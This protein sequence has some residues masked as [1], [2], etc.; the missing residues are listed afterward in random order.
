MSVG[1]NR[2]NRKLEAALFHHR[3]EHID[4]VLLG[5]QVGQAPQVRV[6]DRHVGPG[7]DQHQ[8]RLG[9]PVEK[10]HPDRAVAAVPVVASL[11]WV[12]PP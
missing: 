5:G 1:I 10:R 3:R 2:V 6:G 9:V 4:R 8:R 11:R 7:P 12:V